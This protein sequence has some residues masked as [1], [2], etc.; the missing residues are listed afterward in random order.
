M[1]D[2]ISRYGKE[3]MISE[4]GMDFSKATECKSFLTDIIKKNKSLPNHLGLG[5]FYW[6]PECF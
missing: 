5:V 2:M 3:I 4:V 1:L 6:E